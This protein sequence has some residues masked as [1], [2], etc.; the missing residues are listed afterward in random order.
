MGIR[1]GLKRSGSGLSGQFTVR[2]ESATSGHTIGQKF[3]TPTTGLK[4]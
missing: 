1:D 2:P 4:A 3:V